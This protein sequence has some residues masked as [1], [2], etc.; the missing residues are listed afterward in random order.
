MAAAQ[1]G[2][3]ESFISGFVRGQAALTVG[4]GGLIVVISPTLASH[5]LVLP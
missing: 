2:S 3:H 5:A 4:M 1:N